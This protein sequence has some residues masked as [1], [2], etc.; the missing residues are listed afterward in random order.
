[1]KELKSYIL[2]YDNTPSLTDIQQCICIAKK[3]DC[4]VKLQW[5]VKWSGHYSQI[6]RAEDDAQDI[7]NNHIPHIYGM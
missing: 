3:F 7:Y 4:A 5:T 6:I 1:M 2:D